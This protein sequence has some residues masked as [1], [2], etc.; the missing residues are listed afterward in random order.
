MPLPADLSPHVQQFITVDAGVRLEVLDWGGQ[1]R[2]VLFLSGIGNTAH[3]FDRFAPRFAPRFRVVGIT[4]R[5]FGASSR[6]AT[7]Y[8]I[9]RLAQDIDAV[10]DA[11]RVTNPVLIGHSIAGEEMSY[12]AAR[13]SSR[14]GGLVYLDAAYDHTPPD[15]LIKL[16]VP[17]N[18]PPSP[19]DLASRASYQ[20][21]W[22][23]TRGFRWPDA[24]LN[25]FQ[26]FGDPPASVPKA[27]LEASLPADYRKITAPALAIYVEP[28]SVR[29]L[30]PAYDEYNEAV[31]P[32]LDG[33]WPQWAA[34]VARDRERF[35]REVGRGKT[36]AVAA[37]S[38]YLFISDEDEVAGLVDAFLTTQ[39]WR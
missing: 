34:A 37:K 25:Q 8:T 1:G 33:A 9:P 31:R 2:A 36:T 4:R 12:I 29:D 16:V 30:F 24:E 6:P 38:H 26:Q 14:L 18:L 11:L 23:R 17:A 22:E 19:A 20:A 3:I 13:E 10:I 15:A 28:R 35:Q 7:G 39:A 21:F 5:G 32:Q 27:I